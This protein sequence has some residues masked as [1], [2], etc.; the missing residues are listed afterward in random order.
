MSTILIGILV[1][2]LFILPFVLVGVGKNKEKKHQMEVLFRTAEDFKCNI[3]QYD[4]WTD[5]AIGLDE[6]AN[7]LFFLHTSNGKEIVQHLLLQDF[8]C[9]AVKNFSRNITDREGDHRAIDRLDLEFTPIDKGKPIVHLE[10]FNSE[11]NKLHT[12]EL[13]ITEKWSG[14]VNNRIKNRK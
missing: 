8:K 5:S 4:Y 1:I 9:C 6:M 3:S 10:F 11:G 7:H 12:D 13:L 2:I 14:I